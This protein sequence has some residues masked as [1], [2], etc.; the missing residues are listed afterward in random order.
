MHNSGLRIPLGVSL[1]FGT[2]MPDTFVDLALCLSLNLYSS[3][4][5]G[6]PNLTGT[7]INIYFILNLAFGP[8]SVS[9][10]KLKISNVPIAASAFVEV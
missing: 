3:Q 7:Y 8:Y 2:A 10:G 4:H 9:W 5:S 6:A 1:R